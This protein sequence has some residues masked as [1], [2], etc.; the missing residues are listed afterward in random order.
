[1]LSSGAGLVMAPFRGLRFD[2]AVVGDLGSVISP[3]YDVLDAE[4]VRDLEAG[5][6]RN[7]VRL[8][9]SRHFER[10]YQAVR[11]RLGTWRDQGCLV[12]DPTP[13]LYLY[14]YTVDGVTVRGLIGLVGLRDESE[15]VILPH[16]EVMPG[17]VEDRS[18]LMRTTRTNLEP[19]LLVHEGAAALREVLE[20]VTRRAPLEDFGG[21]DGS[22]HRLWS[23]T[24]PDE[25]SAVAAQ[26]AHSQALIADGH[27]RYAAYL[28][29]QRAQR[30]PTAAAG[31]SP[32]DYGLAMLVDQRDYPLTVGPIHRSVSA[33]TLSDVLDLSAERGDK[34]TTCADRESALASLAAEWAEADSDHAEF[35]ISDGR[36]WVTLTTPRHHEVDAAVLH[37]DLFPA[38]SVTEEQVDYHHSLDQALHTTAR[39]PGVVVGVRPPRLE[40]VMASAARGVRLPRK[41]TSF[42][43]KPSMGL[44]LR[45]LRDA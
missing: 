33:L 7:I 14:Q 3:P 35:V 4:T 17:P 28:A 32:W 30:D 44:V 5:N 38:W 23:L 27:H 18:V 6:R 11:K 10:P 39:L 22:R 20:Q 37:N 8:I 41:S 31:A 9:L 29:L 21:R 26:L 43:P 15:K 24:A 1:M 12:P 13:A 16:E 25:L 2:P 36:T 19:I 34:V 40:Q 45:D 42:S